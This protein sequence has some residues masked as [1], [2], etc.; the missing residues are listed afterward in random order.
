[1]KKL[2]FKANDL[3]LLDELDLLT[4]IEQHSIMG[5]YGSY[6]GYSTPSGY[7]GYNN[8][9]AYSPTQFANIV[10]TTTVPP[11][12]P[13]VYST[14]AGYSVY[15]G[16]KG[17]STYGDWGNYGG[18]GDPKNPIQLQEVSITAPAPGKDFID[19][20][21][22]I[23]TSWANS[24]LGTSFSHGEGALKI[25]GTA[26]PKGFKIASKTMGW[27]GVVDNAVQFGTHPNWNDGLQMGAGAILL[28][29]GGPVTIA[30]GATALFIWEVAE[31]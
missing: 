24:S 2:K 26:I 27:I 4:K 11:L 3:N 10:K 21:A 23:A 17:A 12:S 7:G 18:Y 8:Y 6:G 15:A 19:H 9:G 1:M 13:G 31:D 14:N 30:I 16:N 5:G 20:A 25:M 22:Y 29:F 28:L